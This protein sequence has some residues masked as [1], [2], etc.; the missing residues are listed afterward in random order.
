MDAY[1]NPKQ[2]NIL[3]FVPFNKT[4][5]N[6]DLFHSFFQNGESANV[7]EEEDEVN[8]DKSKSEVHDGEDDGSSSGADEVILIL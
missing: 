5:S 6:T 4:H 7:A 2:V 3:N 8:S 1:N